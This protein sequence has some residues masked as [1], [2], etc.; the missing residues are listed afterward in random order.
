MSKIKLSKIKLCQKHDV[1]MAAPSVGEC[2][3]VFTL[4]VMPPPRLQ[5]AAAGADRGPAG[6]EQARPQVTRLPPGGAVSAAGGR[7]ATEG[8]RSRRGGGAR[9][10]GTLPGTAA[11]H[12]H[13]RRL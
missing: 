2:L 12:G 5:E 6:G 7:G 1:N 13:R 9:R 3:R 4:P 10:S 8:E 11:Q